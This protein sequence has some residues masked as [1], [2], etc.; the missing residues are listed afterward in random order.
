MFENW[1]KKGSSPLLFDAS[2]PG[3]SMREPRQLENPSTRTEDI[4]GVMW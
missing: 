2:Y 1:R 4:S 3:E